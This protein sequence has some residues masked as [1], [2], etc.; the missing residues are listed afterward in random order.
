MTSGNLFTI[1]RLLGLTPSTA[2]K[3]DKYIDLTKDVKQSRVVVD[4]SNVTGT[5]Y[6]RGDSTAESDKESVTSDGK[7]T[8]M[9][10]SSLVHTTHLMHY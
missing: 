7:K 5:R 8:H 1:E 6:E 2:S 9:Q 10:Y 4:L 3:E